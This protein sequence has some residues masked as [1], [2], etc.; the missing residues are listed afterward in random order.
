MHVLNLVQLYR[1]TV[2]PVQN[3]EKFGCEKSVYT[4]LR[5]S[6]LHV[7]ANW[8]CQ[9]HPLFLQPTLSVLGTRRRSRRGQSK[10]II[11]IIFALL[12]LCT[13]MDPCDDPSSGRSVHPIF[14]WRT[15]QVLA[16]G[17]TKFSMFK[18]GATCRYQYRYV[19]YHK[20]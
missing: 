5:L 18:L 11:R 14:F 15:S 6:R 12:N 19:Q 8:R 20:V 10:A 2:V 4:H 13:S 17:T 16:T 1:P 3:L 9:W 7:S